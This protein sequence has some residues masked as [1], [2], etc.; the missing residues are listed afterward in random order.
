MKK[1]HTF[2]CFPTVKQF[3]KFLS[4]GIHFAFPLILINP[5]LKIHDDL[6]FD[7]VDTFVVCSKIYH[8]SI[9]STKMVDWIASYDPSK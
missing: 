9:G 4:V 3:E 6:N 1:P 7:Y 8:L 2:G 5:Y